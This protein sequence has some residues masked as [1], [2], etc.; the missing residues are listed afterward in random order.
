M[1]D[2][3]LKMFRD[4]I[5]KG[6]LRLKL[7][8]RRGQTIKAQN[9]ANVSIGKEEYIETN[10]RV[11][12]GEESLFWLELCWSARGRRSCHFKDHTLSLLAKDKL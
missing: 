5:L 3:G 12:D 11:I 10:V 2:D 7:E 9:G 4:L 6:N 8:I 1:F